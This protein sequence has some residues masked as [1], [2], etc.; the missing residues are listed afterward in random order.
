MM[1]SLMAG[2][3]VMVMPDLP[4]H[5]STSEDSRKGVVDTLAQQYQRM[6]QA[7]PIRRPFPFP[8]PKLL[9]YS[10]SKPCNG[11]RKQ[12]WTRAISCSKCN[13]NKKRF[14]PLAQKYGASKKWVEGGLSIVTCET[15]VWKW[16]LEV[17]EGSENKEL[18]YG[19]QICNNG[20][21]YFGFKSLVDH[22]RDDHSRR[23]LE[24]HRLVAVFKRL[25]IFEGW[26][27][28]W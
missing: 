13:Y 20:Q 26:D 3:N 12:T 15:R 11:R 27:E 9:E 1:M 21:V 6:S 28:N 10:P 2:G 24:G 5:L 18:S 23:E 14:S 17:S 8:F 25:G 7:T 16:H 19:C 4:R 22:L